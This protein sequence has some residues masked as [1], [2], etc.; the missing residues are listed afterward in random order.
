MKVAAQ[1][2]QQPR[3]HEIAITR[4]VD[5]AP[6]KVFEAWIHAGHLARWWG[7]RDRG[8]DFSTP[9]VEV[10]PR[11]GGAFRTCIRSPQGED[12]WARGAYTEIDSPRR[13]AFTH[14]W[15]NERGEAGRERLVTVDFAE[16]AGKTRVSF[17][18]GGFESI[19]ERDGEI[20][21]WNECM[22]RL[23]RYFADEQLGKEA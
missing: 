4:V 1:R 21:G 14:G 15:E 19:E 2:Q 12:Y 18:I 6:G 17:H 7:P 8:R 11:P 13:L 5:G 3:Q 22:D 9:H 20:E 10:D 23:V 16:S